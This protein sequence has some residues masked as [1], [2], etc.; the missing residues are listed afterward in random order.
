MLI[1]IY[2]SD[3]KIEITDEEISEIT[4][5]LFQV[6]SKDKKTISKNEAKKMLNDLF[7]SLFE[8]KLKEKSF[9]SIFSKMKKNSDD[10]IEKDDLEDIT[11][12]IIVSFNVN[13]I[14][15]SSSFNDKICIKIGKKLLPIYYYLKKD[16]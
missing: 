4:D 16:K 14:S 3:K 11:R 10:R 9:N 12:A 15:N 1:I 8:D 7:K 13:M 6:Y 5:N 2:M